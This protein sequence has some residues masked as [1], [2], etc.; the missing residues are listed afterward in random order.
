MMWTHRQP[1]ADGT[2]RRRTFR[3]GDGPAAGGAEV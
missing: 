3:A 2:G 1:P